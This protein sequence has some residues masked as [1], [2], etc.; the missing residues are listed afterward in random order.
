[1]LEHP[2][3]AGVNFVG[4]TPVAKH[5]YEHGCKHH[6]RVQAL[7][8]AKNFLVLAGE[9]N[10][11]KSVRAMVDSCYGCAGERCLAGSILIGVGENYEKLKEAVLK[12]AKKVVVGEGLDPKTTMGPVI[13]L[14]AKERILADIE[15]G[16]KEGADIIFDGSSA[17]PVDSDGYYLGPY[18]MDNIKPE[19][20]LATKEIFGPVIGLMKVDHLS[21]AID[22]INSSN[23][24]NTCSIFTS[25]GGLVQ[26]F[27]EEV[28]PSMVGV[29]LGVPAPMAFFSFGGS[30]E[31]FFG[32]VKVHGTSSIEFFTEKHTT[33]Q[34]W[35][36][37]D[38]AEELNP[39]WNQK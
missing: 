27:T 7:G 1:M 31:S 23:Y 19:T 10:I 2:D 6:K 26:Q 13:S 34:R 15:Q 5:V 4:S 35:F 16:K 29:N 33:M 9:A 21:E 14:N 39:H 37:H 3:I 38:H 22:I 30:K 28:H 18:V 25:D 11:E 8:G 32:D 20:L 12:E 36:T 17:V 24:A